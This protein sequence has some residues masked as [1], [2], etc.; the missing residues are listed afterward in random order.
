M[1][2][3]IMEA[4]RILIIEDETSLRTILKMQLEGAGYH[5]ETASDGVE[6]LEKVRA[7]NPNLVLLDVMMPRMDG[8]EVC[9]RMKASVQTSQIPV[10]M[11]TAKGERQD[12]LNGLGDGANDYLTKP[13][14]RQELLARVRNTLQW[15]RSQREANP[16]T[17]LP[18]NVAIEAEV[19]RRIGAAEPLAFLYVDIDHFKAYND[20]YSYKQGDEAIQLTARIILES[21][22]RHGSAVDFVGHVGGDDFV[23]VTVPLRARAIAD[24]IVRDFDEKS[25]SL[26]TPDDR[27]RG[28]VEVTNRQNVLTAV[29]LMSVTVAGVTNEGRVIT[30][31]GQLSDIA[32]ELKCYGKTREGS[33]VVW[34]RRGE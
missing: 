23:I 6:G 25:P 10:I 15:S 18:G 34:E 2:R 1:E 5:V 14:D 32:A 8:N 13:Y 28:Y 7:G 3:S 21:V 11:L 31:V 33:L 27:E 30:H 12:K 26:Y 4:E 24:Q 9:R 29:P 22:A 20:H 17:G 16:L 19:A